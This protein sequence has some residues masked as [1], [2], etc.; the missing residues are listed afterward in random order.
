MLLPETKIHPLWHTALLP[1]L[2]LISCLSMGYGAVVVLVTLLRLAWN[3]EADRRLLAQ[4]S[5]INAVLILAYVV[6]RVGDLAVSGKLGLVR[7]DFFGLLFLGELALFLAAAIQFLRPSVL[8]NRGRLFG[9]ALLAIAAGSAYRVDAYL[10][11]YRPA[12]GW[13]YFP[14][15]GE[16]VVTVG[17]GAIGVALFIVLSKLFPVVVVQERSGHA[18]KPA[19]TARAG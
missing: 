14:S 18:A 9:A 1:T 12:P 4:M 16:I 15:V 13:R 6:L 17:M 7:L 3:A 19:Q 5:R 11:V 10:S 2:F 8:A